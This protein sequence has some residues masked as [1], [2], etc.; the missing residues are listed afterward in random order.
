MERLNTIQKR[1]KTLYGNYTRVGKILLGAA[2]VSA[3]WLLLYFINWIFNIVPLNLGIFGLILNLVAITF[4]VIA[5]VQAVT[6]NYVMEQNKEMY[7]EMVTQGRRRGAMVQNQS[8]PMMRSGKKPRAFVSGHL[9]VDNINQ[10]Y[11]ARWYRRATQITEWKEISEPGLFVLQS[12]TKPKV[13]IIDAKEIGGGFFIGTWE[14]NRFVKYRRQLVLNKQTGRPQSYS[15]LRNA[16]KQLS[17][18][19]K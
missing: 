9:S 16:K 6:L 10:K 14:G 8:K 2:I 7:R 5:V 3:V 1:M 17:K 15:S 12:D 19:N 13:E 4:V 18:M 11:P